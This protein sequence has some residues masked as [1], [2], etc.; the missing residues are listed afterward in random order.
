M[1]GWRRGAGGFALEARISPA[2]RRRLALQ[3]AAGSGRDGVD[4]VGGGYA[5]PGRVFKEG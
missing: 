1:S 4:A 3:V 2:V 5:V